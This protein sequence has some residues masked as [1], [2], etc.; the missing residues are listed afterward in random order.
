MECGLKLINTPTDLANPENIYFAPLLDTP[1][2][3]LFIGTERSKKQDCSTPKNNERLPLLFFSA[4]PGLR[5]WQKLK[6]IQLS[7]PSQYR[8]EVEVGA[9]ISLAGYDRRELIS[10]K[11]II[12]YF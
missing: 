3:R 9:L 5:N 11:A 7:P 1:P 8:K 10:P 6:G 4:E 2:V 12:Y